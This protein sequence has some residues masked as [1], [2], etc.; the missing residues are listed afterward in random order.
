MST[1][2]LN[3]EN[4]LV[5]ESWHFLEK[6]DEKVEKLGIFSDI[7][8]L[9]YVLKN[10]GMTYIHNPEPPKKKKNIEHA[11]SK[12]AKQARGSKER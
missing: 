10:N 12:T 7:Q 5:D 2:D 11:K 9:G 4:N 1:E 6:V 8:Q 3:N